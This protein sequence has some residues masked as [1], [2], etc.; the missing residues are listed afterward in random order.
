MIRFSN[1]RAAPDARSF[2]PLRFVQDDI[3]VNGI[4]RKKK[5]V[6]ISSPEHPAM[7]V[8]RGRG[9]VLNL[10]RMHGW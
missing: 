1:S 3:V 7:L 5:K 10:T 2:T 8:G 4:E 9:W 6:A